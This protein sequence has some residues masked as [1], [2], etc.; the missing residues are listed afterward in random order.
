MPRNASFSKFTTNEKFTHPKKFTTLKNLQ[1]ND[2]NL[3]PT[4]RKLAQK[5]AKLTEN[6]KRTRHVAKS[7]KKNGHP[8]RKFTTLKKATKKCKRLT[9]A[10]IKLTEKMDKP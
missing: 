2:Q 9:P 5:T 1:K 4:R 6:E 3:T 7:R 8:R 10:Q